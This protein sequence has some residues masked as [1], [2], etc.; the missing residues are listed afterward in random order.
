[1][2]LLIFVKK[3]V[4]MQIKC[5]L[6]LVQI[7]RIGYSFIYPGAGYGGSCFPKDVK[8][9]TKIAK[10]HGY[11]S[12]LITAVEEVND[13]QKLVIAQKIINRFGDRPNWIYFW[14]L[15]IVI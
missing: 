4:Q 8:A 15:G 6:V 1:M 14:Y 5:V 13:A 11:D 2:K 3:W 10:E 9:L 12:K 7:K